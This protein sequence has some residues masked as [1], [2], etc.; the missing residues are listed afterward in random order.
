MTKIQSASRARKILSYAVAGL[1]ILVSFAHPVFA[2]DARTVSGVVHDAGGA[3]IPEASVTLLNAQ[4]AIIGAAKTDAQGRFTIP[5]IPNG[6]YLL[7]VASRGFAERR[8]AINVGQT[9][10]ENIEI[11][12]EPRPIVE[13]VTVTA[14]PGLVENIESV[15]QQV[16]VINELQIEE[17]AKTITAQIANEEVGVHLQRTSPT[18]SGIFVRGLTGNKVNVFVDGVR[19]STA[20]MRGGINSFL[21]LIDQTNLQGVEILR[22]P[23]SAQYGSD[24]IGGSVQFLTLTP[25]F[26]SDGP[27]LRGKLGT[28][29]NTA[30]AGFGSNLATSYSTRKF[31]LI[32]NFAGRRANTLRTGHGLDSHNAVTRFFNLS[33]DLVIDD[34]M[35][36]TAFTQYGGLI[37]M[38]YAPAEGHQLILNYARTQ[39][40][41]GKRFDQL[42]GGD[43]NLIADVRNFTLDFAYARYDKVKLGWFDNFTAVYSFNSQREERV[44]QG[45]NG[46]PRA[47]INH[48]PERTNANG[49]Q[50]FVNKQW[51]TRQN[52]L[53]GGEYYHEWVDAP[54]YGL[55]PVTGI[56][57]PRRG[58]VPHH[59]TFD[60]GGVYAQDIVEVIPDKLRFVGNVR[61]SAA[62]YKARAQES[63]LVGNRILFPDD[64]LRVDDVTFRTGVVVTPVEG[65]S[66]AANVSRGFRA[67]H[68]TDL[69]TLGLTGSGF[70][71]AAPDVAGL[72]GTIGSTAGGDA[73]STGLPVTQ[74]QPETSMN[75]EASVRY[76][77]RR[78]DTDFAFFVNDINDN[79]VKQALILPQGSVGKLL[80]T[81]PITAQNPNGTVFVA[82]STS[83]VLVRAN[84]D[85]ARIYGFEHTL[86]VKVAD[87]WWVATIFTYIHARDKRTD[88]PPN[89]EGGTPAPDGYLK[90]RYAPASKRFW[91]EPYIH[92]ADRQERLS[93]L[94]LE[95]RRTGATRSRSSIASFFTNGARARGLVDAGPDGTPGNADDRLIATGETLAQIQN[96][97]LGVGVNSSPL[98]TAIPGYVTF[99]VRGGYR[100]GERHEVLVEFENIGDRNYRGISWG[101]DAPGR[102]VFAK[103]NLRF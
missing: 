33:S 52:L 23:N 17:R 74:V 5:A 61:W 36:D 90:I 10:S 63:L 83:P 94:D 37:K 75:Y 84:F 103:Y 68:I 34:R 28:Y 72:G 8:I 14:N 73:V 70:E 9:E 26:S 35:P 71:V 91:I 38:N 64:S 67:P 97:V 85:D 42:I 4:R 51:G 39:Q 102:G 44:N 41:G 78:F 27:V 48:E 86:D 54:S 13:E 81:T 66:L 65:L 80:G 21:N 19:Y 93:S 24:A 53:L 92:A 59:A 79:I 25:S 46:N 49:F 100:F 76:H 30:D 11:I 1:L 3:V 18:I 62:K 82:A 2:E 20:S 55:N 87:D 22:G 12:V 99:N 47:A 96:R 89:I 16:N 32:T 7:V 15:S 101:I 29:F 98:Y 43:G 60:S 56:F 88:L 69:G 50:T 57:T 6:S 45:G 77:N 95:D 40:D 31:G 58:R